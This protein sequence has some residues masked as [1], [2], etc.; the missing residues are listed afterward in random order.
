MLEPVAVVGWRL[1]VVKLGYVCLL[2][3]G[4]DEVGWDVGCSVL[5]VESGLEVEVAGVD[6]SRVVGELVVV[7]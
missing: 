5:V 4:V 7:V 3:A 6:I 2:L 1:A